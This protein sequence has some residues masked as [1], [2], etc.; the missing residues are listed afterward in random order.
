MNLSIAPKGSCKII[1]YRFY[2]Q[3]YLEHLYFQGNFLK[4]NMNMLH[5]CSPTV[6]S[7]QFCIR[8]FISLCLLVYGLKS[9]QPGSKWNGGFLNAFGTIC[10]AI[11]FNILEKK[12]TDSSY[13][14]VIII[15]I[16]NSREVPKSVYVQQKRY[17]QQ[18]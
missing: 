15:I 13:L 5:F 1:L 3:Q 16:K 11:I 14:P 9:I 4:H 18:I 10:L 6:S 12:I 2:H 7:N 17:A 8:S